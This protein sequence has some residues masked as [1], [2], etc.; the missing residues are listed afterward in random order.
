MPSQVF[1][2]PPTHHQ[3]IVLVVDLTLALLIPVLRRDHVDL[4]PQPLH[5]ARRLIPKAARLVTDHHPLSQP[6][7]LF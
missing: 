4:H 5:P 7:L 2:Q 1:A 3:R 6:Q